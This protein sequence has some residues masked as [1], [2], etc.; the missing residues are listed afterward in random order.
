LWLSSSIA[1]TRVALL[2]G[3][4]SAQVTQSSLMAQNC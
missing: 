2:H 4:T 1:G 3:T